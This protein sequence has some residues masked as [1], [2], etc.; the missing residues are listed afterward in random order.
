MDIIKL[1]LFF[2]FIHW[3]TNFSLGKDNVEK[4]ILRTEK[5]KRN[6]KYNDEDANNYLAN[7]VFWS[8]LGNH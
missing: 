6:E 5:I 8:D 2:Y 3:F 1:I 7:S 4:T